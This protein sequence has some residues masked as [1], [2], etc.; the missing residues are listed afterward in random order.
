MNALYDVVWLLDGIIGIFFKVVLII[1]A[2]TFLSKQ[3]GPNIEE[4]T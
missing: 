3:K 4:Q 1:L 2:L